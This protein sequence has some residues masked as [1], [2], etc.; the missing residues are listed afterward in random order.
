MADKPVGEDAAGKPPRIKPRDI[1]ILTAAIV[2]VALTSS[3][4]QQFAAGILGAA[5]SSLSN[6]STS[7]QGILL[8][9]LIIGIPIL[10]VAYFVFG[11]MWS[12]ARFSA[13]EMMM[14]NPKISEYNKTTM[15]YYYVFVLGITS[16]AAGAFWAITASMQLNSGSVDLL[17]I[18]S[19]I[20]P[21]WASFDG[22]AI[23]WNMRFDL[24]QIVVY[25]KTTRAG[26][27]SICVAAMVLALLFGRVMGYDWLT[28]IPA[29]VQMT[30]TAINSVKM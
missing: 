15:G 18:S 7:I 2:A 12:S 10:L 16:V 13:Q 20:F 19:I 8:V 25:E 23:L 30:K 24:S 22:L 1:F 4:F 26:Y 14:R 5:I 29:V 11:G 17:K 6:A 9:T 28:A 27:L 3:D 21:L